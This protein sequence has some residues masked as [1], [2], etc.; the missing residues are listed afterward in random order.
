MDYGD[1]PARTRNALVARKNLANCDLL[2][3]RTLKMNEIGRAAVHAL[4]AITEGLFV[5][6]SRL[7]M[8]EESME[9]ASD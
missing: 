1:V 7:E 9:V 6:E 2:A 5:V 4:L 8:L 3:R